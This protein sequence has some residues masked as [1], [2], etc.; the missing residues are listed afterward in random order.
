[1]P[2]LPLSSCGCLPGRGVWLAGH[3]A[4]L[5]PTSGV[6]SRGSCRLPSGESVEKIQ[7]PI[8]RLEEASVNLEA[9][10]FWMRTVFAVVFKAET[11]P[12]D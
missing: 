9:H 12:L 1:M 10:P 11:K 8:Q 3:R 7:E 2:P 6:R 4:T 5:S